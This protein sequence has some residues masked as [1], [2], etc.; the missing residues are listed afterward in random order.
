MALQVRPSAEAAR[1]LVPKIS[2]PNKP[3]PPELPNWVYIR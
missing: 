1:P 2:N 3:F